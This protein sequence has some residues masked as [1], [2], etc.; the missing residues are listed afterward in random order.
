MSINIRR[1]ASEALE[2]WEEGFVYAETLVDSASRHYKVS[3]EDRNLLNALLL[4][5][6]RNKRLLDFW[7]SQLRDGKI[8][9]QV[10][11]HLRVGLFQLYLMGLPDHAAVNE[12]VNSARKGIRGL[13]N[14]LLRKAIRERDTLKSLADSQP[15]A[16]RLSHP[17]WLVDRWTQ[18]YGEAATTQLLEWNQQPSLTTFRLNPLKPH[19]RSIVELSNKVKP[20]A[21]HPDFFTTN[22]LPPREWIDE[23]LIYIQDPA[24]THSVEL[25][26]PRNGESILDACAAPGGKSTQIAALMQN[27]GSLLC[28]DSNAKR[29]PRLQRNLERLGINIA[30]T[31]EWDWTCPPPEK[32]HQQFDA[33]LLDVPCSNTGVMRKRVDARWR[34]TPENITEI[35]HIQQ[36][37]LKHALACLKPGGR[38]IY[39]TCSIEAE[40][41]TK[42]IHTFLEDHPELTLAEEQQIHPATHHTDG[43]YAAL[44]TRQSR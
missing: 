17:D 13:I 8:D 41:N 4:G 3:R 19:G 6:I 30:T 35:T 16:I 40:E 42:L 36:A 14:A 27:A 31:E 7:I 12:T 37:I 25:M 38:L 26:Q 15:I 5:C 11:C 39:S 20:L 32:W 1:L 34:M 22:G 9:M 2:E 21:D 18:Q 43:A 23:G 44:L 24:T 10:R 28:T 33:I 29:L